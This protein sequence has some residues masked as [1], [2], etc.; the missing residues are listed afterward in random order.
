MHPVPDEFLNLH[1]HAE[2]VLKNVRQ[3]FTVPDLANQ[4]ADVEELGQI[5]QRVPIA[6]RRRSEPEE[7]A[8]V[9]RKSILFRPVVVDVRLRLRP[10]AIEERQEAVVKNVDEPAERRIVFMSQPLTRTR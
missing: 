10:R 8:D 4:R 3:P 1:R 5:R 6:K 7:R 9:S 2:E